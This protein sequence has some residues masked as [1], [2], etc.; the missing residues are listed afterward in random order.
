[1]KASKIIHK[2]EKRIKIDF[3]YN[4]EIASIIKQIQDARWSF[5]LKAWHIP[6]SKIAFDQL[7]VRFV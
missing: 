5:S 3:P 6:Y 1:M 2:G 7:K 4:V